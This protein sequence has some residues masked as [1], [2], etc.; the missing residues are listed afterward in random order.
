MAKLAAR[1]AANPTYATVVTGH[2]LGAS[3]AT[4]LVAET[5]GAADRKPY[6]KPVPGS[7]LPVS[8]P[9]GRH[10]RLLAIQIRLW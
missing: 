10:A 2:S 4:L 5:L 8:P 7:P 3:M 9:Q 1:V 6:A